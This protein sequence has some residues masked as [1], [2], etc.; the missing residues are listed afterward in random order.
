MEQQGQDLNRI[1]LRGC[2]AGKVVFSHQSH[3]EQ[4]YRFPLAVERLSGNEDV[5]NV[6]FSGRLLPPERISVGDRLEVRGSLRTFNNKSGVGAKLVITVL[7]QEILPTADDHANDLTLAGTI[8]RRGEPRRTPLGREI[9]DFTLAV[10]RRYGRSDYL[11]CIAWGSLAQRCASMEVGERLRLEGRLQ[12]RVYTKQ[13]GDRSEERVA[14]ECSA[15]SLEAETAK[16]KAFC[17]AHCEKILAN[18]DRV[19]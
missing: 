10:N 3:N 9:C 18:S 15:M 6:L 13:L 19:G 5:L 11:P 14:F 17:A 2:A 12:S 7:A 1:V 4:F 16:E 8:C